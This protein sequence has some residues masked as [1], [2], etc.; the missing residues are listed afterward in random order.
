[1]DL[2]M[3]LRSLEE[4]IIRALKSAFSIEAYRI[5]KHTGVWVG[6]EKVAAIGIHGCFNRFLVYHGLALNVTTDLAPV[7]LIVPCG[8]KD[9]GIR[10]V[11]E[12]LGK[13]SDGSKVE[14][15]LLMD[16]AYNSLMREFVELFNLSLAIVPY[17]DSWAW[18]K[19][20]VTKRKGLVDRDEDCSDTL[21]A[22]QHPSAY[23]LGTGSS[24]DH[25]LFNVQDPPFEIH[26][27][28]RG[29]EVTYHG[30][31]QLVMY[32]ILNLR[33]HKTD[34]HWYFRSLEEVII[35]ALKSSFSIKASR[36]DGLT[37][38][39]V[40]D[41][42][43]A[44]IGIHVSRWISYHGLALNVTT[45]LTPF[46]MIVPCGIKDRGIGSI[47]EILQKASGGREMNDT[48]LM[49]IAYKSL[50]EEFTEIFNLSLECRP[51]WSLQENNSLN[52]VHNG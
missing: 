30:P 18:Q 36:V 48:S 45:D 10:S 43:V 51:D 4:V 9:C 8:I 13:A 47:K 19:S 20:I 34:L 16:V 39:W 17:A 46:E 12:I 5:Q 50:I 24:E 35:R 33:Y 38:V 28:D 25:L 2:D 26:R 23:T 1:M 14:D 52:Q 3:Y 29:G 21:I 22:L 32:P 27:I 42:K 31:G 11:K 44:A 15:T 41:Q 7:K 6:N 40:G 37:G 49:D